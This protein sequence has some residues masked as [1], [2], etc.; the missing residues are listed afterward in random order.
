MK[1][2]RRLLL[3]A[4]LQH[5]APSIKW[6]L[7]VCYCRIDFA[8]AL[9]RC[10]NLITL[11]QQGGSPTDCRGEHAGANAL[12]AAYGKK[13]T[14]SPLA[15][16]INRCLGWSSLPTLFRQ[17]PFR[18]GFASEFVRVGKRCRSGVVCQSLPTASSQNWIEPN[19]MGAILWK[20]SKPARN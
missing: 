4:L 3:N 9:C 17:V 13:L 19:W 15:L 5:C 14:A 6:A 18:I 2:G 12:R 11:A 8:S 10:R 20:K 16:F 1:Y 7:R